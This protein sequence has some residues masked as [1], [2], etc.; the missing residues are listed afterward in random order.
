ML[1][2]VFV[3]AHGFVGVAEA[4]GHRIHRDVQH[5]AVRQATVGHRVFYG[6]GARKVR[7]WCIGVAA[8]RR[9]HDGAAI[10]GGK[11]ARHDLQRIAIYIVVVGIQTHR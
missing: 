9:D 5:P 6:V 4:V 11:G 7:R 3:D 10:R 1:A 8:V 2:A